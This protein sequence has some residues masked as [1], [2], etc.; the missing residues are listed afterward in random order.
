M[1]INSQKLFYF[2]SEHCGEALINV[3]N[4]NI[5]TLLLVLYWNFTSKASIAPN[6]NDL[7]YGYGGGGGSTKG[8]GYVALHFS[9]RNQ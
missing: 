2:S 5:W 3:L 7:P 6:S 9:D 1:T 8:K 4:R